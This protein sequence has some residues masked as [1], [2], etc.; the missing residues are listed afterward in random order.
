MAELAF[1]G[2]ADFGT[3]PSAATYL[4]AREQQACEPTLI[5]CRCGSELERELATLR[6]AGLSV[7]CVAYASDGSVPAAVRAMR[8]GVVDYIHDM[9]IGSAFRARVMTLVD[10]TS[11]ARADAL[12]A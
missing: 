1:E 3:F 2:M 8:A 12:A 9:N 7:P 6:A 11:G 4:L 5:I 10:S